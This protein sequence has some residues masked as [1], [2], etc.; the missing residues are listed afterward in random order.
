MRFELFEKAQK[1]TLKS[2]LLLMCL[3]LGAKS[4]GAL[5]LHAL[6][7]SVHKARFY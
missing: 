3:V 1:S 6:R 2:V 4:V 5:V 7:L